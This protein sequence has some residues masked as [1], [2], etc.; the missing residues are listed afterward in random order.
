MEIM[1]RGSF[2]S[3]SS[4]HSPK[5]TPEENKAFENALAKYDK[6]TPDRWEKVAAMV[7]G[8]T[9]EDVWRQYQEL[10]DDVSNIEA[11]LFPFPGYAPSTSPFT[12]ELGNGHSYDGFKQSFVGI[13]GKRSPTN[14]PS[15]QE[16]KKGVPWTEEEHRLFLLGLKKY[17]KGD[18][19]NISRNFVVSRTP[20]QVAS[21]AQK[22]FI[23]QHSGGKDKRR[24]SIHDIT[25]VNLNDS[26]NQIPSPD[27]VKRP[28]SSS[29]DHHSGNSS[30]GVHKMM[31]FQWNHHQGN[32]HSNGGSVMNFNIGGG[33]QG[34]IFMSSNSPRGVI[35]SSYDLK[36]QGQNLQ[37]RGGVPAAMHGSYLGCQNMAFQMQPATHQFP[38]A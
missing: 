23:R 19:R 8:K 25:T 35:N 21:H 9:A 24:A 13:T 10:L 16:R 6:D 20:T 32:N 28:S 17:G 12:L 7:P 26:S 36:M 37:Q 2:N 14:R 11:G 29:P 22:Y 34:N 5:W 18:W 27:S 30:S 3:N 38:H 31:P 33:F 4:W 1:A 15:E